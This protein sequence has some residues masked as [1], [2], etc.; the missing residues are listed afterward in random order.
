[1]P[2]AKARHSLPNAF[3]LQRS[4]LIP[5]NGNTG[6]RLRQ[7]ETVAVRSSSLWP[8]PLIAVGDDGASQAACPS[9]SLQG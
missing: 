7:N 2:V 9:I 8:R 3:D 6:G 5:I 1:M 4:S